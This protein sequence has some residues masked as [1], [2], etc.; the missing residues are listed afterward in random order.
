MYSADRRPS[1]FDEVP[2]FIKFP[3]F[4][5]I[6]P[7]ALGYHNAAHNSYPIR[8]HFRR[9]AMSRIVNRLWTRPR[10]VNLG[11]RRPRNRCLTRLLLQPLEERITPVFT[12]L[13][14]NDAGP[15]S[16]RDCVNQA[17][18][19]AGTDTI[20]FDPFIFGVDQ[21]IKLTGPIAITDS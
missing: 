21:V 17:N 6:L 14:T 3:R 15:D 5:L 13:N 19:M 2:I 16:L 8:H 10:F 1:R 20:V 7:R 9:R 12:V 4:F 11:M 18:V